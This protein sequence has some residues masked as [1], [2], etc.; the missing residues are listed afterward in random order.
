MPRTVKT[1][2]AFGEPLVAAIEDAIRAARQSDPLAPVTVLVPSNYAGLYLRRTLGRRNGI[3]GV[4][5]LVPSR[6]IELLASPALGDGVRPLTRT[7]S[8]QAVRVALEQSS[9][10]PGYLRSHPSSVTAYDS[11]FRELR[12]LELRPAGAAAV[13]EQIGR[14]RPGIVA[15]YHAYRELVAGRHDEVDRVRAAIARIGSSPLP[16]LGSVVA[17]FPRAGD[18]V[19]QRLLEALGEAGD[20]LEIAP[21][22]VEQPSALSLESIPAR[23]SIGVFAGTDEQIRGAIRAV[24]DAMNDGVPLHRMAVLYP[25]SMAANGCFELFDSAGIP[26]NG[27]S[28]RTLADSLEGRVLLR[29][30]SVEK[31][32]F[33]RDAV[34]DALALPVR[35]FENYRPAWRAIAR[36]A[37]ITTGKTRWQRRLADYANR[38][39]QRATLL[40]PDSA[41]AT[42]LRADA[43]GAALLGEAVEVLFEALPPGDSWAELVEWASATLDSLRSS[44]SNEEEGGQVRDVIAEMRDVPPTGPGDRTAFADALATMLATSPVRHNRFEE[45]VFIGRLED[46]YGLSF[47]LVVVL[48]C[49]EGL[50]PGRLGEDSLLAQEHREQLPGLEGRAAVRREQ[51]RLSFVSALQGA[52]R[53]LLCFPRSD[54]SAQAE[55]LPSRWLLEVASSLEGRVLHGRQFA[56]LVD[57]A[58]RPGWLQV[59][60]SF[61][62]AV[63]SGAPNP[64]SEL[65]WVLGRLLHGGPPTESHPLLASLPAARR[66]ASLLRG[67]MAREFT[68][69]DGNLAGRPVGITGGTPNS[70][71]A[72]ERWAACGLQYLFGSVLRVGES[73]DPEDP[74]T[75][76]PLER[77][78]LIHEIM[79]DFFVDHARDREPSQGWSER[80]VEELLARTS[81]VLDQ[82]RQLFG[83]HVPWIVEKDRLLARLRRFLEIDARWREKRGLKFA[84]AEWGFGP[85][86]R[87]SALQDEPAPAG[88]IQT[89]L[90][91]VLTRG[92][93]DRIDVSVDG[94][95]LVVYDY[96]TGFMPGPRKFSENPFDDGKRLQLP[97]YALAAKRAFGA[98]TVEAAYWH[99]LDGNWSEDRLRVDFDEDRIREF[100]DIVERLAAGIGGGVFPARPKDTVCRWCRYESA[101]VTDRERSFARKRKDAAMAP[102]FP[103]SRGFEDSEAD[104][105]EGDGE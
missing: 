91:P 15:A 42:R 14:I 6:A 31:E 81:N 96:K 76:T 82:R 103:T 62:A 63:R 22:P 30:L 35:Q 20:C 59:V 102:Y 45:G 21:P 61:E 99:V 33:S 17:V 28:G 71:T 24:G 29:L 94:S 97:I 77:G 64:H 32:D 75:L 86:V 38:C 88:E 10:L 2:S 68:P 51:Q 23:T 25:S 1:I 56:E 11:L 58:G 9:G 40:P 90:G 26:C 79:D 41:A 46:A 50:L 67:R 13:L 53:A 49:V 89:S 5:F 66:G 105:D 85:G 19:L 100:E 72:L 74:D 52:S 95:H 87:T 43:E 80:E 47:D 57:H 101:C 83:R 3:A 65:E 16:L 36:E 8:R 84:A 12:A 60:P 37:G 34:L 55:R 93:V 44:S 27:V 54:L 104:S 92:D 70:P 78:S 7:Y 69:Y 39:L 73:E 4:S 98:S 18:P 48:D